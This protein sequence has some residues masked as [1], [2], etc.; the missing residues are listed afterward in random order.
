MQRENELE[1]RKGLELAKLKESKRI[2]AEI[3]KKLQ[4]EV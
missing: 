2:N 3:K 4:E 1:V